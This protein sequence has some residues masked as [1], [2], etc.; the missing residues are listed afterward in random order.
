[1]EKWIGQIDDIEEEFNQI[2]ANKGGVITFDEFCDWAI[3]KSLD[4]ESIVQEEEEEQS[5]EE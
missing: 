4:G 3:Q 2:D 5:K 1:M